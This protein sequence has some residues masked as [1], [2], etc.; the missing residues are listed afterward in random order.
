MIASSKRFRASATSISVW[1]K[2]ETR[3]SRLMSSWT[4]W[5]TKSQTPASEVIRR[6]WALKWSLEKPEIK[7]IVPDLATMFSSI[8]LRQRRR[9]Q[10]NSSREVHKKLGRMQA[11]S[12]TQCLPASFSALARILLNSNKSQQMMVSA[13]TTAS[14]NITEIA[15]STSSVHK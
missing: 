5:I 9:H 8:C 7:I 1:C 3:T 4:V 14:L 13:K 2:M 6:S 12:K 15:P 10:N 11:H